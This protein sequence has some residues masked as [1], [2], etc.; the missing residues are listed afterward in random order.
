MRELAERGYEVTAAVLHA[1]DTDAVIAESLN[2][3]RITVPPL[4]HIDETSAREAL[5]MMLSSDLTV[6]CDAPFGPGNVAN[7][8]IALEAARQGVRVL[9]LEQVPISERDFT[10]GEAARLWEELR[11]VA[12]VARAY[13]DIS[14]LM[15]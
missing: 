3:L 12:T 15:S 8:R 14:A 10:G 7:L 2:L 1:T 4:S 13:S 9:L 5:A 11:D 6:V